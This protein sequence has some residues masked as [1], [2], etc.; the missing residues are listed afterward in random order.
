MSSRAVVDIHD[1]EDRVDHR[2]QPAVDGIEEDPTGSR[3]APRTLHRRRV[4]GH[5]LHVAVPRQGELLG[6]HLRLLVA[7]QVAPPV[8]GGLRTDLTRPLPEGDGRGGV[9]QALHAGRL[10]GLQHRPG[11]FDVDANHLGRLRRAELHLAGDVI[12]DL[13]FGHCCLE[14]GAIKHI[15]ASWNR[16]ERRHRLIGGLRSGQRPH[17]ASGL[18]E[19]AHHG[20]AHHAIG[21]RDEG[22]HR[23]TAVTSGC[24]R[25]RLEA[26]GGTAPGSPSRRRW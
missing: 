11:A 5:H 19:V 10:G 13:T 21:A 9:N 25:R 22:R 18:D 16:S 26:P 12:H 1:R 15:A 6:Q 4:D 23:R 17:R 14:G 8:L 3:R 20:A 24:V 7:G 2:R